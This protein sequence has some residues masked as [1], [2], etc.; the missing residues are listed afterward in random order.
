MSCRGGRR[1]CPH[2][3]A[4]SSTAG[5]TADRKA[6]V[7]RVDAI[8]EDAPFTKAM[9]AAVRGEIKALASWLG[10]ALDIPALPTGAPD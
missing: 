7:L 8:H 10:L 2:W 4:W 1:Y 5:A 6:G 9:T 3:T